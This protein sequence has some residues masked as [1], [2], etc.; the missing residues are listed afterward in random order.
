MMAS[1]PM[2]E[3]CTAQRPHKGARDLPRR[4]LRPVPL[5]VIQPV[6]T[7]LVRHMVRRRPEFF[8]RLA[9]CKARRYLIAPDNLPFAFLFCPDPC[10]PVLRAVRHT[11]IPAHDAKISA[12]FLTLLDMIDGRRDGDA[13]FFSRD[14]SISGDTEAIVVL[15]NALD[16]LEGNITD[17]LAAP[18]G[19]PATAMLALA[20]RIR[21]R[22]HERK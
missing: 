3:Q 11:D 12:S 7:R 21:E 16:D 13:L 4:I 10:A 8:D 20:R 18:F 14:L 2:K 19:P 17:D 6:L 1:T 22:R 15:R 9:A 5:F